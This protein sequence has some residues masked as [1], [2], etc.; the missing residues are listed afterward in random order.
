MKANNIF[1]QSMPLLKI[2]ECEIN[3]GV[4]LH[5]S[6]VIRGYLTGDPESSIDEYLQK[7]IIDISFLDSGNNIYPV[8]KGLITKISITVGNE[9]NKMV[10]NAESFTRKL[11][12]KDNF[13][14]FQDKNMT[15]K[16]IAEYIV[17][18][19]ENA[20]S[21]YNRNTDVPAEGLVVQ[22]KETDWEFLR[23]IASAVNTVLIPDCKNDKASFYFGIPERMAVNDFEYLSI[24][25][26]WSN[27]EG[28][29]VQ[30]YIVKTTDILNLC[31]KVMIQDTAVYVYAVTLE[32]IDGEIVNK[33]V[34]R[35]LKDFYVKKYH[36][37]NLAGVSL[38]GRVEAVKNT[39]VQIDIEND[40]VKKT[41]SRRWFDFATVYSSYDGTGWYCMPEREDEIRLYFPD[42]DELN[43]YVVSAV[44]SEK[45]DESR[46]NPDVKFLKTIYEKEIRLTPSRIM[47]SNHKGMQIILDD[48]E[49]IIIKSNK[50]IKIESN[51]A[52]NIESGDGIEIDANMGI[53]LRQKRNM[54]MIRDGISEQGLNIEHR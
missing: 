34:L 20:I 50:D 23:R 35:L 13:R 22:Y 39:Q 7:E 21:I 9:F 48:N 47:L 29:R 45:T 8:F 1:I 5:F 11:D 30:E 33:Y 17:G 37:I 18:C 19:Q 26:S 2:T 49:G 41:N 27:E 12:L 43:A 53:Y 52:L 36:N 54:I 14:V 24:I 40:L 16:K 44:H 51:G 3:K 15:Y 32:M 38:M 42:C 4:N 31:D 28:R 25:K 10:I 6:A 46:T